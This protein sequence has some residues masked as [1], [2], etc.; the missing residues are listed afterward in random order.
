MLPF[1]YLGL[2]ERS[3]GYLLLHPTPYYIVYPLATPPFTP[4][5]SRSPPRPRGDAPS[6]NQLLQAPLHHPMMHSWPP[7][8]HLLASPTH[9]LATRGYLATALR[10][11]A[12]SL[13]PGGRLPGVGQCTHVRLSMVLHSAC[14]VFLHQPSYP[15]R[16]F[17]PAV[18]P[19]GGQPSC[20]CL[21]CPIARCNV[22]AVW[23]VLESYSA[24]ARADCRVDA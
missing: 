18:S 21:K 1:G 9:S 17:I 23:Q 2:S 4:W 8:G 14:I 12:S 22:A 7:F 11:V 10:T 24:T 5:S 15:Q 16:R 13:L 6:S 19:Q 20:L 3:P